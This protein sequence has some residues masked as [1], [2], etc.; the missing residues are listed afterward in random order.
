MVSSVAALPPD[1]PELPRICDARKS[2]AAR[3][4]LSNQ[5]NILPLDRRPR[6]VS[7]HLLEVVAVGSKVIAVESVDVPDLGFRVFANLDHI[8]LHHGL[9]SARLTD[10]RGRS[11]VS[12]F[13]RRRNNSAGKSKNVETSW[14]KRDSKRMLAVMGD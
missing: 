3:F 13:L 10:R 2:F 8:N 14:N 11:P 5:E 4:D 12:T 9:I 1:G 7:L 6:E